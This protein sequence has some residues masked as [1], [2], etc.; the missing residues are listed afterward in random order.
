MNTRH[1]LVPTTGSILVAIP[2]RDTRTHARARRVEYSDAAHLLKQADDAAE[3]AQR[4]EGRPFAAWVARPAVLA[5]AL[6]VILAVVASTA[7]FAW[8]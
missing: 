4:T 8:G 3:E 5:I 7:T 1:I 2:V 6:A